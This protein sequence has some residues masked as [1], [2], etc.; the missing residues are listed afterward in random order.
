M[1]WISL[2]IVA[3]VFYTPLI[4]LGRI[5]QEQTFSPQDLL[6]WLPVSAPIPYSGYV[7]LFVYSFLVWFFLWLVLFMLETYLV[8][9]AQSG[10]R[11][12]LGRLR[13]RNG[14]LYA[15]VPQFSNNVAVWLAWIV[16]VYG[17]ARSVLLS[18]DVKQAAAFFPLE[19][20]WGIMAFSALTLIAGYTFGFEQR[21]HY[22]ADIRLNQA[23]HKKRQTEIVVP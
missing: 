13:L 15:L 14:M 4:G 19:I 1:A 18:M 10:Q 22:E 9:S 20:D 12:L 11:G 6:P 17:G 3:L 23:R 7:R 8:S 16:F 21:Y 2:V 5:V